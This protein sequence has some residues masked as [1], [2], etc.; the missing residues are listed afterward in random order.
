MNEQICSIKAQI[1]DKMSR[2]FQIA[3]HYPKVRTAIESMLEEQTGSALL[4]NKKVGK[5]A[6]MKAQRRLI[7]ASQEELKKIGKL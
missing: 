1:Q 3:K 2:V 4:E 5:V 6:S 7:M